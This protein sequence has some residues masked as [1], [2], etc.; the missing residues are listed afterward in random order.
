M[1]MESASHCDERSLLDPQRQQIMSIFLVT[2]FW[3][4]TCF[5][6]FIFVTPSHLVMSPEAPKVQ[7]YFKSYD[8]H[9]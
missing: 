1:K 5:I 6:L 2:V 8:A 7:I 9:K 4:T 3:V